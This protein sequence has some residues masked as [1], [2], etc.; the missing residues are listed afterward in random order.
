MSAE[1][2]MPRELPS[3]EV[4]D[5]SG[6]EEPEF[7]ELKTLYANVVGLFPRLYFLVYDG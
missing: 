2:E 1:F 5:L 6:L 7:S 3:R 4:P